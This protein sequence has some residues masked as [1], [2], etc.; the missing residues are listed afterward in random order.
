[1]VT[2]AEM[3]QSGL[4]QHWVLIGWKQGESR[5]SSEAAEERTRTG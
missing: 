5:A 4:K 1:M 3:A 2:M